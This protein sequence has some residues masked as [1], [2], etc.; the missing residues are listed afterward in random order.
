M[1][2]FRCR[3]RGRPGHRLVLEKG[4]IG[5]HNLGVL[6][7]ALADAGAKPDEALDAFGGQE[8]VA[9]DRVGALADAVHSAGALNQPDDRPGQVEVH[10]NGTILKVL[11]L[12]EDVGR[13]NDAEFVC[14]RAVPAR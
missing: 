8:R 2:S 13:Q 1:P 9:E 10:N 12:A 11:A 7:Q 6:G 5:T 3:D 4:F 14:R